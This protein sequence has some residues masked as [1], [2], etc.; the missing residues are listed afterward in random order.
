MLPLTM[1]RV[2]VFETS[3]DAAIDV[4]CC[5]M[6]PYVEINRQ[7]MLKPKKAALLARTLLAE[8]E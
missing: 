3:A 7:S 5:M 6:Y 4:Y 8:K 1:Y 2:N